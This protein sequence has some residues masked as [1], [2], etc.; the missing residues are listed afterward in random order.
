ME[1]NE[2][3]K[4]KWEVFLICLICVLAVL[5]GI[6]VL[7]LSDSYDPTSLVFMI[8]SASLGYAVKSSQ[9]QK[10]TDENQDERLE[11]LESQMEVK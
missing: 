11:R 4:M 9:H 3:R 5:F 10:K 8:L 2:I 7:V 1:S 6:I